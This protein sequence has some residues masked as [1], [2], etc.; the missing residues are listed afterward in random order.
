MKFKV[1]SPVQKEE[2]KEIILKLVSEESGSVEVRV[3]D[4]EGDWDQTLLKI[5]EDGVYL[6]PLTCEYQ[7]IFK[8]GKYGRL[9]VK[10]V[11]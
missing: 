10:E 7:D 8:C 9:N 3:V 11:G 4:E 1:Y 6:P 2:E 5:D